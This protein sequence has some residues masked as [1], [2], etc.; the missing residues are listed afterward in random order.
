M[1]GRYSLFTLDE[2]FKRYQLQQQKLSFQASYNIAPGSIAPTISS[3]KTSQPDAGSQRAKQLVLRKWGFI[4]F[5]SK[6]EEIGLRMIN[7]RAE[8][9]TEK[10]SFRRAIKTQRCLVPANGFFEW[11]KIAEG[12][13]QPFYI[14]HKSLKIMSLAGIY[15]NWQSPAGKTVGSFSIITTNAS[16]ELENV[17]DRMPVIFDKDEEEAWLDEQANL[18]QLLELLDPHLSEHLLIYPVNPLVNFPQNNTP[19]VIQSM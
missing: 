2:I 14:K 15:D 5:W 3:E 7:A 1:C 4:P 19:E 10:A 11:Q 13:K 16:K 18:D 12:K 17:H 8:T 6:N 9:I